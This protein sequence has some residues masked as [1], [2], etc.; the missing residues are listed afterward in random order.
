[1]DKGIAVLLTAV[2][3]RPDRPSGAD[4]RRARQGDG[5]LRRRA[6]LLRWSAPLLLAAIV[7]AQRQG[8][9]A[10][11]TP[12][13]SQWYYLLGGLLGAVYVATALVAVE[14]DRRRRRRGRDGHGPAHGLGGRS[15]GSASS[16]SSRS[17]LTAER[18]LGRGA[19]ARRD[20]PDRPLAGFWR[21]ARRAAPRSVAEAPISAATVARASCRRTRRDVR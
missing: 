16:G 12:A 2:R 11:P 3:R 19:A 6:G 15:T 9:A 18:I 5:E 7:V 21:S 8:R 17:P 13:T 20:L 14:L 10:S 4:Q 1:M